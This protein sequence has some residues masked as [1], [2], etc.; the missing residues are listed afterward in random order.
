MKKARIFLALLFAVIVGFVASAIISVSGAERNSR[1][2]VVAHAASSNYTEQIYWAVNEDTLT[3]LIS[4]SQIEDYECGVFEGTR[5]FHADNG[6]ADTWH[7]W[8]GQGVRDFREVTFLKPVAPQYINSWFSEFHSLTKINNIS[9]L[10]TS[11]TVGAEYAFN[12]CISL[13]SLDLSSFNATQLTNV[14]GMF[15]YLAAL[16]EIK[17]SESLSSKL[18]AGGIALPNVGEFTTWL[19]A[20]GNMLNSPSQMTAAGTYKAAYTPVIWW[21]TN[22]G[23]NILYVDS[24]SSNTRTEA[25]YAIDIYNEDFGIPWP[26]GDFTSI[27][28]SNIKPASM[29]MWFDGSSS[30]SSIGW[31][32]ID[33]TYTTDMSYL[34]SSSNLSSV[35]FPANFKTGNVK[36]MEAMFGWSNFRTLDLSSFVTSKVENMSSMFSGCG[37]LTSIN[38]SSFEF[39][40]Q[41]IVDGI[42]DDL[43]M[44]SQINISAGVAELFEIGEM[45]SFVYAN[46]S[47]FWLNSYGEKISSPQGMNAAGVYTRPYTP[48][49]W[50]RVSGS[51]LYLTNTKTNN[52]EGLLCSDNQVPWYDYRGDIRNVSI[53]N[54]IVPAFTASWFE[55]FSGL[56]SIDL[57]NLDTTYTTDMNHMFYACESLTT[58]DLTK[59]KTDN[60]TNMENMFR[61]CS[62][63]KKFDFS[64]FNVEKCLKFDGFI[65]DLYAV[66]EITVSESLGKR[67]ERGD[68]SFSFVSDYTY[69]TYEDENGETQT[70][71]TSDDMSM[72]TTYKSGYTARI[73][74]RYIEGST[75][76]LILSNTDFTSSEKNASYACGEFHGTDFYSYY[77]ASGKNDYNNVYYYWRTNVPW[78]AY[79]ENIKTV[80]IINRIAPSSTNYWFFQCGILTAINGLENLDCTYATE[81]QNMF[82]GCGALTSL[83]LSSLNVSHNRVFS[84]ML[85]GLGS[86]SEITINESLAAKMDSTD[87]DVISADTPWYYG[88]YEPENMVTAAYQMERAGTYINPVTPVIYWRVS[89]SSNP[90][91]LT[92]STSEVTTTNGDYGAFA[93]TENTVPWSGYAGDIRNVVISG[94]V[95][96]TYTSGWFSGFI[97]IGTIDLSALVTSNVVDMSYMFESCEKLT[98]LTLPS[99]FNTSSV[100]NMEGMFSACRKLTQIDLSGFNASK[101]TNMGAMFNECEALKSIDLS[102]LDTSLVENMENMFNGCLSLEAL[103]LITLNFDSCQAYG[104]MLS[105]LESLTS[106]TI[107][108]RISEFFVD[109]TIDSFGN[110]NPDAF[111]LSPTKQKISSCAEMSEVGTYTNAYTQKIYWSYN[112]GKLTLS[113]TGSG[114]PI[115][116][117]SNDVPWYERYRNNITSVEITGPIKPAYTSWWFSECKNLT[118][119]TGLNYL[120][121]TYTTHM[122]GMFNG[123]SSL[124]NLDVV[125]LKTGNVLYM[126]NMFNGCTKLASLNVSAFDTS[127]VVDMEYM[128]QSCQSL[129]S[130]D[131]SSF[132]VS[133]C[134]NCYLMFNDMP[135]LS[136]LTISSSVSAK[137][138]S[139]KITFDNPTEVSFWLSPSGKKVDWYG[140]MSESG[141]YTCP[142]TPVIYWSYVQTGNVYKLT[143]SSN[144]ISAYSFAGTS[145][146]VPWANYKGKITSVVVEGTVSPASTADWFS[147]CTQLTS[148]DL[149]GLD[150]TYTTDMTGMFYRCISLKSLDL[151][152][153][154]VANCTGFGDMFTENESLEELTISLS[155]SDCLIDGTIDSFTYANEDAIWFSPSGRRVTANDDMREQG[156]YVS[157]YTPKIYWTYTNRILTLTDKQIGR[158]PLYGIVDYGADLPWAQY[159]AG[160]I[161]SVV[162]E[163]NVRPVYTN[164]WFDGCAVLTSVDLSGLNTENTVSMYAMFSE[165][166]A[167]Q[168]LDLSNMVTSNVRN[169]EYMFNNCN[170]LANLDLSKFDMSACRQYTDMLT[171]LKSLNEITISKSVAENM[172]RVNFDVLGANTPWYF[173][174]DGPSALIYDARQMARAG[175]YVNP[176]SAAIYWQY[177]NYVLTISST[178]FTGSNTG[179]IAVT[180]QF[181]EEEAPWFN[182]HTSINSV[183][184]RGKVSPAYTSWWFCSLTNL[185]TVDLTGLDTSYTTDMA[186]M[187]YNCQKLNSLKFGNTFD[188]SSVVNMD[189]M[190]ANC[191]AL[192]S[193]DLSSFVTPQL[194]SMNYMFF[195]DAEESG[196]VSQLAEINLS[197]INASR[198]DGFENTFTGLSSI[199]RLNVN[200]SLAV[201]LA[202]E[203]VAFDYPNESAYWISPSGKKIT[204]FNQMKEAGEYVCPYSA[205]IYWQY[206]NYRLTISDVSFASGTSYSFNTL[207]PD[208]ETNRYWQDNISKASVTSVMFVGDVV[209]A[210]TR[211]WFN[212]FKGLTSI[213]LSCLDTT[214]TTDMAGMFADC[215][216]LDTL[217]MSGL[218]VGGCND[219]ENI[220]YN[221]SSL[222]VI[223]LSDTLANKFR[224]TT[225]AFD[226]VSEFS[227]W[228]T[229]EGVK[230][231]APTQMRLGTM[232]INPYTPL[233]YWQYNGG[234]LRLSDKSLGGSY[235]G[236][237]PAMWRMDEEGQDP[238]ANYRDA[239]GNNGSITT[240]SIEAEIRP[241]NTRFWF[242]G[243]SR[244]T[245]VNGLDK[246]TMS[247][248]TDMSNMFAECHLLK[249][250]DLSVFNTSNVTDTSYAFYNCNSLTSLDLS[251]FNMTNCKITEGML[252]EL[253]ALTEISI[254]ASLAGKMAY[255]DF[256][257]INSAAW[258]YEDGTKILEASKM[259][260]A[261]LYTSSYTPIIYWNYNRSTN[262][263]IISVTEQNHSNSYYGSFSVTEFFQTYDW[264]Y[265]DDNN[266]GYGNRYWHWIDS[267]SYTPWEDY[268]SSMKSVSFVGNVA[269]VNLAGWFR[270]CEALTSVDLSGLNAANVTDFRLMFDGCISLKSLD[271]SKFDVS[272]AMYYSYAYSTNTGSGTCVVNGLEYM[273]SGLNSLSSITLSESLAA[274][275]KGGYAYLDNVTYD[276]P[277]YYED[278]TQMNDPTKMR[279][280][281]RYSSGYTPVLYWSVG[282][283]TLTIS[284]SAISGNVFSGADWYENGGDAPWYGSRGSIRSVKF[285]GDVKPLHTRYWFYDLY[286][287]TSAD[288]SGLDTMFTRDME[289]MFDS[290]VRL[291][292]IIFGET[293]STANAE[294]MYAMFSTC[295]ALKNLDLRVFNT[296]KVTN[297]SYMFYACSSLESL[298]LSNFTVAKVEDFSHMLQFGEG[299]KL[300]N[301]NISLGIATKIEETWFDQASEET[302]WRRDGGKQITAASQMTSAG[303]YYYDGIVVFKNGDELLAMVTIEKGKP[304]EYTGA[305]PTKKDTSDTAYVDFIGWTRTDGGSTFVDLSTITQSTTVYACFNSIKIIA[306]GSGIVYDGNAHEA[307]FENKTTAPDSDYTVSY[308]YCETSNGT[309]AAEDG[310]VRAGW[311]K[312]QITFGSHTISVMY[313]ILK[314]EVKVT[315]GVVAEDKVYDATTNA[316]VN[317]ENAVISGIAE[318]DDVC[319]ASVTA[320]FADTYANPNVTVNLSNWVLGGADAGNYTLAA[321]GHTSA[322]ANITKRDVTVQIAVE[323]SIVGHVKAATA[324]VLGCEGMVAPVVTLT[325][326]NDKGYNS[327]KLPDVPALYTVTATIVNSNF[328]L[329]GENTAEFELVSPYNM[330]TGVYFEKEE[331][332]YGDIVRKPKVTATHGTNT[333]QITFYKDINRTQAVNI[334]ET[335]PPDAGTYYVYIRVPANMDY[336]EATTTVTLI[337]NPKKVTLN[338]N[339]GGGVYGGTITYPSATVVTDM[340]PAPAVTFTYTDSE[341]NKLTSNPVNAGTYTAEA[342]LSSKNYEIDGT[343]NVR[344][345]IEGV[346]VADATV[347]A[348]ADQKY[349]GSAINPAVK[350]TLGGKTLIEKTDYTVTYSDNINVWYDESGAVGAGA[351]IIISGC[352]NYGGTVEVSFKITPVTL[353]ADMITVDDQIYTGMQIMP[354][355]TARY[356]GK[357]L[358][359][360]VD[361]T[362][363][364]GENLNVLYV[365]QS[366]AEGGS[367]TLTGK[368][369]FVGTIDKK[370]KIKPA[371][372]GSVTIGEIA[373]QEYTGEPIIPDFAV[374]LGDVE[375]VKDVDYTAAISANINVG[376]ATVTLTGKGNFTGSKKATFSIVACNVTIQIAAKGG[377]VNNV[378]PATAKVFDSHGNELA[379]EVK[380]TYT[381]KDGKTSEIVPNVIGT[382]TVTASIANPNYNVSGDRTA[383]FVIS[384]AS[385]AITELTL[386][387]WIFGNPNEPQVIAESGDEAP[388]Y[389]TYYLESD[390]EMENPLKDKPVDVGA[391]IVKAEIFATANYGYAQASKSFKILPVTLTEDMIFVGTQTYTG[392]QLTPEVKIIYLGNE[393]GADCYETVVYGGNVNVADGGTVTVTAKGNFEGTCTLN[394]DIEA[395]EITNEMFT[396][397]DQAF[398]G[399]QLTPPVTF[400]FN[401]ETLG[402]DGFTVVYGENVNVADGGSVTITASGNFSGEVTVEFEI[403]PMSVYAVISVQGAAAGSVSAATAEAFDIYDKK[404]EGVEFIFTYTDGA[405]NTSQEVPQTVGTYTVK[406]TPASANYVLT[407]EASATFV[408]SAEQNTATIDLADWVYGSPNQPVITV[409][410][411]DVSTAVVTYYDFS[412]T[413]MANP[414][415]GQ[416]VNVG[417]YRVKVVIPATSNYSEAVDSTTFEITPKQLTVIG[418]VAVDRQFDGTVA[419]QLD[420]SGVT[421]DG[422]VGDDELTLTAAGTFDGA[423]VGAHTVTVGEMTLNGDA[424]ANYTLAPYTETLSATISRRQVKVVITA[425]GGSADEPFEGATAQVVDLDGNVIDTEVT[426]TYIFNKTGATI[427]GDFSEVGEY[428]VT[429]TIADENYELTGDNT[430]TFNISAHSNRIISFVLE[431]WTY[432]SPNTPSLEASFGAETVVYTYYSV[433]EEGNLTEIGNE[434]PKNAGNYKVVAFVPSTEEYASA[435]GELA[436]TIAQ[437]ALSLDGITA[438]GKIYDG[439]TEAQLGYDNVTF[440]GLVDGDMLTVSATGT[441]A[442]AD[443]GTHAVTVT[444]ISISGDA[445]ANYN[446]T[447]TEL[448][449]NGVVISPKSVT[450]EITTTDGVVGGEPFG[451]KV[452]ILND[453][454]EIETGFSLVYKDG[455]GNTLAGKP[456]Q[457]GE[458]TVEV[459]LPEGNYVVSGDCTASFLI[460]ANANSVTVVLESWTF[461]EPNS[462]EITAAFGGDTAVIKY[463][464]VDENGEILE[465][466][467]AKPENAGKYLIEV[468]IAAT[469]EYSAAE[470][471]VLFEIAR[472][473][474]KAVFTIVNGLVDEVAAEASVKIVDLNGNEISTDVTL[475]FTDKEGNS[476]NEV[477]QTVGEYTVTATVADTNYNLTGNTAKLTVSATVNSITEFTQQDWTYGEPTAPAVHAAY[478]EDTAQFTYY[479]LGEGEEKTEL[480]GVPQ[481]VG[482]YEVVVYI[483]ATAEYS[484]ATASTRFAILPREITVEITVRGGSVNGSA[485]SATA[486]VAGYIGE[487]APEITFT[488]KDAEGNVYSEMP[489]VSGNYTAVAAIS[490]SNYVLTGDNTAEF[491]VSENTNSVTV[492]LESWTYGE[493]NMPRITADYGVDTAVVTYCELNADGE[494]VREL[495]GI[496]EN[497]GKY[498]IKVYIAATAE[499][500]DAEASAEFEID[501]KSV[502]V[503]IDVDSNFIGLVEPATAQ[504]TDLQG[505]PL[506][507]EFVITYVAEDGTVFEHL[508]DLAGRY[509][510]T[511]TIPNENYKIIGRNTQP[512]NILLMGGLKENAFELVISDLTY[513][514]TVEPVIEAKTNEN[515]DKLPIYGAET[516][517]FA[518]YTTDDVDM[519]NPLEGKPVNVGTYIVVATIAQNMEEGYDGASE[520]AEFSILAKKVTAV[521]TIP[522]AITVPNGSSALEEGVPAQVVIDGLYEGDEGLVTVTYVSTDEKGYNDQV[523][524]VELGSYMVVVTI[525]SA[526][527]ELDESGA[528]AKFLIAKNAEDPDGNGSIDIPDDREFDFAIT[529]VDIDVEHKFEGLSVGRKAQ[530]W[531]IIDGVASTTEFTGSLKATITFKVPQQIF[532]V[533]CKNGIDLEAVKEKLTLYR[534]VEEGEPVL[535]DYT[536]FVKKANGDSSGELMVK[537]EYEGEFPAEFVFNDASYR[538]PKKGLPWWA[539]LLIALGCVLVVGLIVLVVVV[540]VLKKR[541]AE[542]STVYITQEDEETK[543]KLAEHDQKIEE[544]LNRDDGGFGTVVDPDD[545]DV[546]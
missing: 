352:G 425:A 427:E 265:T 333:E 223:I 404:I 94:S 324:Q 507:V 474:V 96:P 447:T 266:D 340:T 144:A 83:D 33:T 217:D 524:P 207:N 378:V 420:C 480:E 485:G 305:T 332:F 113:P 302:P 320:K 268:K 81:M 405:G 99:G 411:G 381:D 392:Q 304:V 434:Q 391:Y 395:A 535:M 396:V 272:S 319:V 54:K 386:D 69:W 283:Y 120:D 39:D 454:V 135:A 156:K 146:V 483:P 13:A 388:V 76:K 464:T 322:V 360:G 316:T 465:E 489:R 240:V 486:K 27:N 453:G 222:K 246:L 48:V 418:I 112:S 428:T 168:S 455:E 151:S 460:S 357:S 436:F 44:L 531:E 55:G 209:P 107:S 57:T 85:C 67:F 70:I 123:C 393:Y 390:T 424:A 349:T 5:N 38:M 210:S 488:F 284:D 213:D 150:T 462:P 249:T 372:L 394:F 214:Y 176:V 368:G 84:A 43:P 219:F 530:L 63:L 366:V 196:L 355:I 379:V 282:N 325:Y 106:I 345:V 407:E 82:D 118:S 93:G 199:R 9:N 431:G 387:D 297:M 385:N 170:S 159:A 12:E 124:V 64:S 242:Y 350:I 237:F 533:I 308:S 412:D 181:G 37:E 29:R 432:G 103:N 373:E 354:A 517:T 445:A 384:T 225:I 20:D 41:P 321:S 270:G 472:K 515:G 492:E 100:V 457:A 442:S 430:A 52:Y 441:F 234:T 422:L 499:Y 526:N 508:P 122:E 87:F 516:V 501:Y 215:S 262:Q 74:W 353:T 389:F 484:A 205:R 173:Y 495:D 311:H 419:A 166:A 261:G 421:F 538:A 143:V 309:F 78:W 342:N 7:D 334:T 239:E 341:G 58:V 336:G 42:F 131:L 231:T 34:L 382:Y 303:R 117:L 439:T 91:T 294:N 408:V 292:T 148:V 194:T 155:L 514:E 160:G 519:L 68:V 80:D 31:G 200:L 147:E 339:A 72:P 145:A 206:A 115:S 417:S 230:V 179:R 498:L 512:L 289:G 66:E 525:D 271:M 180:D 377:T 232:Y 288:L 300:R 259:R 132:E 15:N 59:L 348:V 201:K 510:V 111:W 542:N 459:T 426:F 477:P 62:M 204:H 406:A 279:W 429:A 136:E 193:L 8:Y 21:G 323:D 369:N 47:M 522:D 16:G 30:L 481:N 290:C 53:S 236:S 344:F 433:D 169:M 536:P 86:L 109:G 127:N 285:T 56:T 104:G 71:S 19:D 158:D 359:S 97:N 504:I 244:L 45:S 423:N 293:F 141:T 2:A 438:D 413:E 79:R 235:S 329:V 102:T 375:M 518:Y 188:V 478:G 248:V 245:A 198:C 247:Y 539:W 415:E 541:K 315:G 253:T 520:S 255:V 18:V 505:N 537:V 226:N 174:E 264:L 281:G 65:D 278:G 211:D 363:E 108:Q 202:A 130:L 479:A 399:E 529:E 4:D 310:P 89:Y 523:P 458:Y 509:T 105:G 121:T 32:N 149:S 346:S 233:I 73:F 22:S 397:N 403:I 28:I 165:C 452:T 258:Y 327:T 252:S 178:P 351:K 317:F 546:K 152:R 90:V 364:Y 402:L 521:I 154:E 172:R 401:G 3:L 374:L 503:E 60:V 466:L 528:T 449:I 545:Y 356:L 301:I 490:D 161:L 126:S 224:D 24:T 14:E 502:L 189:W 343:R 263:L 175:K 208:D 544:L 277:W 437:K 331:Y 467:E 494:V 129:K 471:G 192:K 6:Y 216:K 77:K 451:V 212:G 330:I 177:Y 496:P 376:T 446:L 410:L 318:G 119:V 491:V 543:R 116:G 307:T 167:I 435:T 36:S 227:P 473:E 254:S 184:I 347:S 182:Y 88:S 468:S 448:T 527:Y 10:D 383:E 23:G 61:G 51:S 371:E 291:Q 241:A 532:D 298:D 365:N 153:F 313:R 274:K 409:N 295:S 506:D 286:N 221:L 482:N 469:V 220:F 114:T 456:E 461:G 251:S 273:I 312:A 163:G 299:A 1:G 276:T 328:N 238:W 164:H 125:Y 228:Y 296:E 398:S 380:F 191:I 367:V 183:A 444:G 110:P 101:V 337:V 326:T 335:T 534:L 46:G 362:A 400:V 218:N 138:V 137:L 40:R 269:P 470:A 229:H 162:V 185:T 98:Q 75:R 128:F 186:G 243:F 25:F 476:F 487:T 95:K 440:E 257:P 260:K 203:S 157:S 280:A 513:G 475:T 250:L 134:E 338:I 500:E 190:F 50:W 267:G 133:Y 11:K 450:V 140:A 358:V 361:Y 187:F 370:F 195:V 49:I 497:V 142:Y 287:L 197:N 92:I 314:K 540:I 511:V 139:S 463:Y 443:A 171:S 493:P 26:T 306:P 17:I 275:F 416:P 35:T 256:T 414:L